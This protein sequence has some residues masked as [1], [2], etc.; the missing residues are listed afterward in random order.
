[1]AHSPL[2]ALARCLL[3]C[4]LCLLPGWSL[5]RPSLSFFCEVPGEA[6][7]SYCEDSSLL[8][9]LRHLDASVRVGL[10][11]LSQARAEGIRRL[12]AAGIPVVAWLLLP[13]AEGYWLHAQ[14]GAAALSRYERFRRWTEEH[15]LRWEGVGLDLEPPIQYL[16]EASE[17]PW[18]SAWQGYLRLFTPAPAFAPEGAYARLLAQIR[19]DGYPIETYLFPPIL[20]ERATG[21][22]SFQ[23]L[24]GILDI[25]A[26]LEIPMCYTS[27]GYLSPAMIL[28]YGEDR[29]A[30]ALGSTGGGP[31][32]LHGA[33]MP[34]MSWADLRRDLL[35]AQQVCQD[36]H[37]YSLEGCVA[38]EYLDSLRYFDWQQ[39]VALYS[40]EIQ[41]VAETRAQLGWALRLLD[42]PV[43]LSVVVLLLLGAL[44]W[45]LFALISWP[46]RTLR[47]LTREG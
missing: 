24:S 41:Q 34:A 27:S 35:L 6:F 32:L 19:D 11:D 10:L 33:P 14:N 42:Y 13:E 28:S 36:I 2:S 18:R 37:L 45:G 23:R 12:N 4:W 43:A 31:A 15:E 46:V 16:H 22:H 30:I 3:G 47:Q 38:Q 5:A 7:L 20:D 44:L 40:G 1:M 9:T 21:T 25:P 8:Q 39:P 29:P 17:A 26:A